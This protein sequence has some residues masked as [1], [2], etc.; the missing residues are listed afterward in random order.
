MYAQEHIVNGY[1]ARLE[2]GE[3]GTYT[4]SWDRFKKFTRKLNVNKIRYFIV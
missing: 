2:D 4:V 1:R 3:Y